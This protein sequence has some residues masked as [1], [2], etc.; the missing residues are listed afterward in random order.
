MMFISVPGAPEAQQMPRTEVKRKMASGDLP[1]EALI[2]SEKQNEWKAPAAI[3]SLITLPEA[4]QPAQV[5]TTSTP[6]PGGKTKVQ[7]A[8]ARS[9]GTI[10]K[11]KANPQDQPSAKPVAKV[12]PTSPKPLPKVKATSPKPLP[13]PGAAAPSSPQVS[14]HTASPA[15]Q[16]TKLSNRAAEMVAEEAAQKKKGYAWIKYLC[17]F[18]T[19]I[20][21]GLLGFN[22]FY[23]NAP[24]QEKI[25]E[26]TH[27]EASIFGHLG[28]FFQSDAL[29]LHV[30]GAPDVNEHNFPEFLVSLSAS[31]PHAQR[32]DQVSLTGG[33]LAEYS[34][35]GKA[36]RRLSSG[37]YEGEGLRNFIIDNLRSPSG[38]KVMPANTSLDF[39]RTEQLRESV[40]KGFVKSLTG[41]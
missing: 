14:G 9:T 11:L 41:S 13:N 38:R 30:W 39:E 40:W 27:P 24:L 19:V 7:V 16:P 34:F 29:A 5:A 3:S 4:G 10:P 23:V 37:T 2:W 35:T 36:W 8:V 15:T 6:Y 1:P 28:G 33:W 25:A 18:V 20:V 31:T 32:W 17:A 26:S 12:K 22:W 21:L